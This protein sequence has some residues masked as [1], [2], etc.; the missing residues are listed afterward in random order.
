MQ[1]QLGAHQPTER[2]F[3]PGAFLGHAFRFALAFGGWSAQ[4]LDLRFENAQVEG[5]V[6]GERH[7]PVAVGGKIGAQGAQL[8]GLIGV[9]RALEKGLGLAGVSGQIL[10]E[11][12][13]GGLAFPLCSGPGRRA[14]KSCDDSEEE[15]GRKAECA[16][17]VKENE[18]RAKSG[19]DRISGRKH[20]LSSRCISYRELDLWHQS[21]IG[22]A[23]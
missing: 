11:R 12:G 21:A 22:A 4:T 9:G 2:S 17:G 18:V 3:Q 7:G 10:H 6:V 8:C 16:Q 14:A 13:D 20:L 1:A 19:A 5:S 23:P 15:Q